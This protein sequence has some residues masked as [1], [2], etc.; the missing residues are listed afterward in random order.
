VSVEGLSQKTFMPTLR[1]PGI[2]TLTP[3]VMSARAWDRMEASPTS[4]PPAL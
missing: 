3:I 2:G 1:I 4:G